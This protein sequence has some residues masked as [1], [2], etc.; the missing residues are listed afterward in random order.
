MVLGISAEEEAEHD[1]IGR[2]EKSFYTCLQTAKA[3][4]D[5]IP[6]ADYAEIAQLLTAS[7]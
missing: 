1:R 6:K 7:Q 5:V 2:T 4:G 3:Q